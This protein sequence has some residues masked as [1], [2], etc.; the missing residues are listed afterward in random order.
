M[1]R[2]LYRF[3]DVWGD[4]IAVAAAGGGGDVTLGIDGRDS[5]LGNDANKAVLLPRAEVERL[6]NALN[7]ILEQGG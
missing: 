5:A 7:S 3:T 6:R 4:E 2:D 1:S